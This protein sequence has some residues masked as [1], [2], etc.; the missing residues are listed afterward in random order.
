MRF[1]PQG[2]DDLREMLAAV[3]AASPSDLFASIPEALR[4]KRDLDL[5][6]PHSELELRRL[7]GGMASKNA[8]AATH[9]CFLG[10]G[11]YNHYIPAA[12]WQILLRSEFYTSY[13]PYQPEISQGT[14]QATFE[15]QS[16]IA[17]L[18]EMEISNASLYDGASAL[19]E[20]VL[21]AGR[22]TR[23]RRV[24]LSAAIHPHYR[25]VVRAYVRNLGMEVEEVPWGGDGRT[26]LPVLD[27]ALRAG[28]PPA[29]VA[30]QNPNFFGCLED[31]GSASAMVHGSGALFEVVVNEPLS[32]GLLHGPGH[33]GADIALGEAQALGMPLSLGGPFLG[34]LAAKESLLRQMPGRLVGEAVDAAGRR[35]Y[36]L[37]LS[38]REQH[39]RREKA[40]SNI[41]T[42][43]GLIATAATIYMSLMG[44]EGMREVALQCHSKAAHARELL[45]RL[46]G[47]RPR[48]DAPFF[49]E[50]VI[51]LPADAR[52]VSLALLDRGIIGGLPLG[53]DG[54]GHGAAP[55][56]A[57]SRCML[58]CVTEMNTRDEI[59]RL[60]TALAAVTR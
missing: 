33:Y 3:G 2:D 12:V 20:G 52:A 31:L 44:R 48:F 58:F 34:F 38:T 23:R 22:V 32:L 29:M 1:F 5:P 27:K 16:L 14:L 26:D 36:V 15:F 50:F 46:P 56:A 21:M 8:S 4:L 45:A 18:T 25:Q 7:M 55:D 10:A 40:T 41:C 37:T 35:G 11:A 59:E 51:E 39:I 49:N 9:A 19:A 24:V 17:A 43:Q 53:R 28:E 13:T 54:G 30:L 42:N 6:P 57:L 47:C 60:A